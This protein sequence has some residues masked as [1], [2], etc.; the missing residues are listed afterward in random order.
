MCCVVCSCLLPLF[1]SVG[2]E[3]PRTVAS[4]FPNSHPNRLMNYVFNMR[5]TP[6]EPDALPIVDLPTLDSE[7]ENGPDEEDTAMLATKA[8]AEEPDQLISPP[9]EPLDASESEEDDEDVQ[10]DGKIVK[11]R[12]CACLRIAVALLTSACL[13]AGLHDM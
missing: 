8:T 5:L 1:C 6:V 3:M 11:V 13:P 7:E 4:K 9:P 10:P 12:V 2:Y